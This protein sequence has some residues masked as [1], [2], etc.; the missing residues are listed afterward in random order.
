MTA[1]K[2]LALRR[3]GTGALREVQFTYRGVTYTR[4]FG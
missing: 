2:L 1:R 3:S 4:W